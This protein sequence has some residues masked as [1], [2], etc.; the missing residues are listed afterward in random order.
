M[1]WEKVWVKLVNQFLLTNLMLMSSQDVCYRKGSGRNFHSLEVFFSYSQQ[2]EEKYI[3]P[4]L[5]LARRAIF[6]PPSEVY[7]RSFFLVAITLTK[8]LLHKTLSDSLSLVLE[9][10]LLWRQRIWQNIINVHL[11]TRSISLGSEQML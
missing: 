7:I 4:C 6:L 8:F 10:N 9:L 5:K 2:L 11:S 3:T 1:L